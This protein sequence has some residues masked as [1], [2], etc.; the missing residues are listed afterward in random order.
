MRS[1]GVYTA[2]LPTEN[3]SCNLDGL[4]GE[5]GALLGPLGGWENE[6]G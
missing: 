2:E 1:W 3:A 5:G 6:R 4:P